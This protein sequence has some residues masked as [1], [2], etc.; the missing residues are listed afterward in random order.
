MAAALSLDELALAHLQDV[1]WT[2]RGR[3]IDAVVIFAA[4]LS[5]GTWGYPFLRAIGGQVVRRKPRP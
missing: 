3:Q 4:L 2:S 1:C 5:V